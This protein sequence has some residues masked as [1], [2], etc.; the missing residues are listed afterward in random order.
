MKPVIVKATTERFTGDKL[1]WWLVGLN[2]LAAA[3]STLYF[4]TR[5]GAGLDGW[6]A[7]NSCALSIFIFALGYLIKNRSVMAVGAGLLFRYGTLGLFI[8][9][10]T[11]I[12]IIPQVGHILM[13]LALIYFIVRMIRL[14]GWDAVI[15][16]AFVA[17]LM[18]YA[19][20]QWNW[21]GD[22]PWAIEALMQGKLSPELFQ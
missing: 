8:F 1:G 13:T 9:G 21:F 12:N 14:K 3:N 16:C 15:V 6:L 18:L 5:L 19:E 17:G 7:M 20:W 22:R 10:W 4:T 2:L 11:G